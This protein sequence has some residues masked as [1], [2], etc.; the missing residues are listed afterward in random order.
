MSPDAISSTPLSIPETVQGRGFAVGTDGE[1]GGDTVIRLGDQELR[2]RGG[3]GGL[4]GSGQR[5]TTDALRVS[6]ILLAR[7]AE[8]SD[9]AIIVGGGI[10]WYSVLNLPT[11][12]NVTAFMVFEA[13]SVEDGEYTVSVEALNPDGELRGRVRFPLT[14]EAQGEVVRIAR[15]C[16][17][18]VDIDSFGLWTVNVNTT[19]NELAVHPFIVKRYGEG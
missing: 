11:Q 8:W 4:A 16:D 12:L 1:D 6:S 7:Y 19:T 9:T 14:V 17:V 2:A 13:G 3:Q 18:T 10:V 15:G 5:R